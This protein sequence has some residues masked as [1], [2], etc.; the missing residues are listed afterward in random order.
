MVIEVVSTFLRMGR[1][2]FRL[3]MPSFL[4]L[5]EVRMHF[6]L[7]RIVFSYIPGHISMSGVK[8]NSR[9]ID[10]TNTFRITHPY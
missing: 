7:G 9:R 10:S 8:I 5:R 2:E 1:I 6:R 3:G 4:S